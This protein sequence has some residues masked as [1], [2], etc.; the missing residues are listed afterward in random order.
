MKLHDNDID[1][2]NKK[3]AQ[4]NQKRVVKKVCLLAST[5]KLASHSACD[6]RNSSGHVSPSLQREQRHQ[7]EVLQLQERGHRGPQQEVGR[8]SRHNHR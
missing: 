4:A 5:G 1:V 6:Q 8:W 7:R 2:A 3:K